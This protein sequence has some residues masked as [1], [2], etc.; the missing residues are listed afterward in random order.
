MANTNSQQL[1]E[2]VQNSIFLDR[3]YKVFL[4]N[5]IKKTPEKYLKNFSKYL[6]EME[7]NQSDIIK[8]LISA[9]PDFPKKFEKMKSRGLKEFIN[10]GIIDNLKNV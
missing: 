9:D 1:I 3:E 4:I 2:T 8:K 6:A 10:V 5:F 7:S